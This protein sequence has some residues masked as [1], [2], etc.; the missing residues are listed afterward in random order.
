MVLMWDFWNFTF[1][2]LGDASPIHSELSL[3]FRVIGKTPGQIFDNNMV[4]E[5]FVW[6][7]HRDMSW[8]DVT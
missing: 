8:K 4:K 5:I 2:G 1:F 6:I 3:Y 7:S